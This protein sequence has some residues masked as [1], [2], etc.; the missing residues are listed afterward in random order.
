MGA[1]YD[2]LNNSTPNADLDLHTVPSVDP[3]PPRED[4]DSHS[5]TTGETN[6]NNNNFKDTKSDSP[7]PNLSH[8]TS[9]NTISR[10]DVLYT[11]ADSLTNKKAEL[12][13][14][15][16]NSKPDII[17]ITETMPKNSKYKRE[18]CELNI[19]GYS[20]YHITDT[21]RGIS[22]YVANFL[23]S[24][25]IELKT[26]FSESIWTEIRTT[27]SEKILLGCI[28]RSPNSSQE[29]NKL[30]LDQLEEACKLK[31]KHILVVGDFNYKEVDWKN[32]IVHA[33]YDNP[34]SHIYNKINDL[35]L[36][37][38]VHEPTRFR[39]GETENCLDWVLT[40]NEES[41]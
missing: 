36:Q 15:V 32:N 28:Y 23:L 5:A 9:R 17:C 10:L 26:K 16:T 1:Q 8:N 29:N 25:Q 35:F 11:N 37:Q 6:N 19:E 30:L 41:I 7:R 12:E 33:S 38:I 14:I 2:N 40:D 24:T 4:T 34:A 13:A 31:Y 20:G 18:E 21:G 22:V 27:P 3:V 39:A